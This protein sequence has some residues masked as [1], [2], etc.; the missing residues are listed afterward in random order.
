MKELLNVF[1][2]IAADVSQIKIFLKSK[3][4]NK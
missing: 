4:T 2:T 1:V 3:N